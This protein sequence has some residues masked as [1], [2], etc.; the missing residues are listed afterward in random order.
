MNQLVASTE[1][2]SAE[3]FKKRTEEDPAW[4]KDLNHPVIVQGYVDMVGSKIKYLS[5]WLRFSGKNSMGESANFSGSEDLESA[6]GT[7][8]GSV[9]FSKS[10]IKNIGR[11][12]VL[13]RYKFLTGRN[14]NEAF[15]A[16]FFR[17]LNLT[18]FSGEY[19]YPVAA[20]E[21]NISTIENLKVRASHIKHKIDLS[22]NPVRKV[23]PNVDLFPNEILWD[24]HTDDEA[25]RIVDRELG[26]R[27]SQIQLHR[28][29]FA[30]H[31]NNSELNNNSKEDPKR[32]V[33]RTI[34]EAIGAD[35]ILVKEN[36]PA[37]SPK[38]KGLFRLSTIVMACVGLL[39]YKTSDEIVKQTLISPMVDSLT[40]KKANPTQ[41]LETHQAPQS[42]LNLISERTNIRTEH[43]MWT[44]QRAE[45]LNRFAASDMS[46]NDKIALAKATLESL[47]LDPNMICLPDP[48][49]PSGS[50]KIG[51]AAAMGMVA[52][53]INHAAINLTPAQETLLS[54]QNTID[55]IEKTQMP[56]SNEFIPLNQPTENLTQ[57]PTKP[58]NRKQ[59]KPNLQDQNLIMQ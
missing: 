7:F 14:E 15:S 18:K 33:V 34:A 4:A 42:S 37:S 48:T 44:T 38:R 36:V 8:D 26:R 24:E 40:S 56:T 55:E 25:K 58:S 9:D 12:K 52:G 57:E 28:K 6:E 47:G 20:A 11:L 45:E 27:L 32:V 49:P 43:G 51:T 59:K 1:R 39:I 29:K 31:P 5:R 54:A 22:C 16:Y 19:A 30:T 50:L 35:D 21:S 10:G 3:E 17:C 53:A 13:G 46:Y 2:I 41:Y 23:G